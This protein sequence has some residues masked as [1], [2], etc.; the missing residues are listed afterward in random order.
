MAADGAWFFGGA[1]GGEVEAVVVGGAE[2]GDD[3]GAFGEAL[4][5]GG[6]VAE[7]GGEVEFLAFDEDAGGLGDVGE[8]EVAAVGGVDGGFIAGGDGACGGAEAAGEEVVEGGEVSGG[9][10]EFFGVE[11]EL[12]DE[13]GDFF[14]AGGAVHAPAV[15]FGEG[16]VL[17][18]GV[19]GELAEGGAVDPVEEGFAV[20]GFFLD[21]A[22]FGIEEADGCAW[23]GHYFARLL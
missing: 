22:G 9:F 8:A 2:A 11:V 4:G 13:G 1:C 14:S 17:D 18:E 21:G 19:E 15:P 7:E 23:G 20:D 5:E 10:F 12:A 16:G 6:V 3:E